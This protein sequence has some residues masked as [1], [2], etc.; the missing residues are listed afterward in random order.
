M[1]YLQSLIS[2]ELHKRLT[3]AALDKSV[4]LQELVRETLEAC[5]PSPPNSTKEDNNGRSNNS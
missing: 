5:F 4:T 2:D 3:I 1:R